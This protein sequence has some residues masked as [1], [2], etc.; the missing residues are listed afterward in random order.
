MVLVQDFLHQSFIRF[1]IDVLFLCK[2]QIQN[3]IVNFS[4]FQ[5][6]DNFK[7]CLMI[8]SYYKK[9]IIEKKAEPIVKQSSSYDIEY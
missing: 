1:W 3:I 9:S 4:N 8:E 6:A 2:A 7:N 5:Q